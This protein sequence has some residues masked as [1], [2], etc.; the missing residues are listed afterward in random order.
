MAGLAPDPRAT[1]ARSS[2][3]TLAPATLEGP[4]APLF[5]SV[6]RFRDPAI[7]TAASEHV[8]RPAPLTCR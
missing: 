7:D 1:S 3:L 8:T 2:V 4:S 6:Q 5:P